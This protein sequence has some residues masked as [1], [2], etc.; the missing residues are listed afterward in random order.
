M[1]P[2]ARA[3][4]VAADFQSRFGS[5]PK[6]YRAPGR[7]NL[8]GEHTDYSGGLV[9][10]VAIDLFAWVALRSRPDRTIR[11]YSATMDDTREFTIGADEPDAGWGRYVQGVAL[12]L[13]D[14]GYAVS[15][16]DILID[17]DV[18]LGSGLSSSAALEVAFG[19]AL[20]SEAGFEIEKTQLAKI[21]QRAE[22]QYVG[23]QCGIMDQ[24]AAACGE[25]GH[26]LKIDCA[27]LECES[28]PIPAGVR[29]I[30]ANTMVRHAHGAGE[31]N[32]RREEL[33]AG[34]RA[35]GDGAGIAQPRDLTAEQV[36]AADLPE[37]PRKRV[38]HVM[39][40]NA[41]VEQAAAALAT[42]DL[43]LFGRLMA[44]SHRSLRDDYEVSCPELDAMVE[45]AAGAPG[46]RG[47]RMTGGGFGGCTV[48]LVDEPDVDDFRAHVARGYRAAVGRDPAFH[49][50]SAAAGARVVEV[51][52]RRALKKA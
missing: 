49:V 23:V 5:V 26:A 21:C 25:P 50:C 34:L 31:Y 38:R 13:E 35:L 14:S 22:N 40:E 2:D 30:V 7:V 48:S 45:A 9:M 4:R 17:S 33:E 29:I 37:I 8:I 18:P 12:A 3:G 52:A 6:V 10:P 24:M 27:S 41:R 11:A 47:T 1:S 15:G 43:V 42:G 44:Q 51:P 32:R 28:L 36:E 39:T 19:L 16:A 20:S 46:L